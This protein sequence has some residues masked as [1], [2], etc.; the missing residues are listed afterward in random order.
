MIESSAESL[1]LAAAVLDA[2]PFN[3]VVGARITAFGSGNAELVLDIED[4]HR[5]QFGVAHG[6]VLAYLAD[7]ALTFAAGSV[8]GTDVLTGGVDVSYLR[9][10]RDGRL[11]TTATVVHRARTHA[12]TTAEIWHE[13]DGAEPRLCAIA[14]GTVFVTAPGASR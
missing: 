10:A 9:A 3:A 8:L 5:Q 14:R 11:R 12:V 6:G 2:Q 7:N 1:A 4:R 13:T